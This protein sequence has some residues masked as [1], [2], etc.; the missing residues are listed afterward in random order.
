MLSP[1][2]SCRVCRTCPLASSSTAAQEEA[3][4]AKPAAAA[5]P[6]PEEV[7]ASAAASAT[8]AAAS[9]AASV[10]AAAIGGYMRAAGQL[11]LR[12]EA[13][14]F[15]LEVGT[16]ARGQLVKVEEVS[17]H[18]CEKKEDEGQRKEGRPLL[19]VACAWTCVCGRG[20]EFVSLF[21][22]WVRFRR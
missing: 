20:C 14:S 17:G 9:A 2:L 8:A 12:E 18:G 19:S 21:L 22:V 16:V 13:D 6:S 7:A 10:P 11:K 1:A 4:A 15:S 3:A 5:V